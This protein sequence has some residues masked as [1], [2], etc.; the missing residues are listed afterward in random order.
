MKWREWGRKF[1][2]LQYINTYVH[3]YTH[4]LRVQKFVTMTLGCGKAHQHI[5]Y[6]K[7]AKYTDLLQYIQLYKDFTYDT[8]H[9]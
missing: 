2:V 9:S 7:Y 1:Y 5:K 6:T 3:N 8:I 4:I